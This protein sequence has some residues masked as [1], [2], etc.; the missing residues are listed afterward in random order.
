MRDYGT[1][2]VVR[3]NNYLEKRICA[4]GLALIGDLLGPFP[5]AVA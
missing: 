2:N 4:F 3:Y 5:G 1:K